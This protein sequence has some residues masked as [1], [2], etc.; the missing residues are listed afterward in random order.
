VASGSGTEDAY[1]CLL[2]DHVLEVFDGST[3]VAVR[4]AVQPEK[5]AERRQ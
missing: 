5:K 4:L 2:C 3:D 1:R